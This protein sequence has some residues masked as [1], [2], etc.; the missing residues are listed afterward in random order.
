MADSVEG[1][2]NTIAAL[3]IRWS[4]LP[5]CGWPWLVDTSAP[6]R[7]F[8]RVFMLSSQSYT[9]MA[10]VILGQ[11]QVLRRRMLT[12]DILTCEPPSLR[13]DSGLSVSAKRFDFALAQPE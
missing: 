9:G 2:R 7:G 5:S 12:T 3:T 4:S 11:R 8:E 10:A 6:F 13:A 1:P